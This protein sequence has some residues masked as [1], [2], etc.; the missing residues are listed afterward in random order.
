MNKNKISFSQRREISPLSGKLTIIPKTVDFKPNW[1]LHISLISFILHYFQWFLL[2]F[3]WFS[4]VVDWVPYGISGGKSYHE[5]QTYVY[6]HNNSSTVIDNIEDS[7][8]VDLNLCSSIFYISNSYLSLFP[9]IYISAF[10]STDSR[11]NST[12]T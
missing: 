6:S 9:S 7:K 8:D 11:L 1:Y 5:Q 2:H 4:N 3:P 12:Y 10:L